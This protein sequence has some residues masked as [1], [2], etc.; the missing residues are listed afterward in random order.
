MESNHLL[1][2]I[3]GAINIWA[4][5]LYNK[6]VFLGGT[7]PNAATWSLWAL[8]T[9]VQ[10]MSYDAMGVHWSKLVVMVS[11]AT[12]CIGTFFFLWYAGKFGKLDKESRR[13]VVLGI[14][15]F[16]LWQATSA[17]LGNI[18]SQIP[19]AMAFWPTIR[20]TRDGKTLEVPRVWV[21]FTI[22]FVLSLIVVC[23]EWPENKWEFLF[24]IVA[25][26]MHAVLA[27][28]AFRGRKLY[29]KRTVED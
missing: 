9:S 5:W 16:V 24:P 22:S 20:N 10:A 11:D 4:F 6:D 3:A 2:L 19:Y 26:V 14:A 15:A 13:I 7:R 1:A 27:Y 12:L 23:L 8:V 21:L 29:A 18:M 28:Y 25:I 17:T